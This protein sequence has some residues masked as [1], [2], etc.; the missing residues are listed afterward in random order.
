MWQPLIFYAFLA[1]TSQGG[2]MGSVCDF[3][4]G[5]GILSSAGTTVSNAGIGLLNLRNQLNSIGKNAPVARE[6]DETGVASYVAPSVATGRRTTG[7]ANFRRCLAGGGVT[8]PPSRAG[9]LAEPRSAR[10]SRNRRL[11]GG[12][13]ALERKRRLARE[14]MR[15]LRA[16]R[17]KAARKRRSMSNHFVWL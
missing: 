11:D 17:K 12:E 7:M 3:L 14:S 13:S 9:G 16:R 15:R 10:N 8:T 2:V 5:I 4:R 1:L 6:T